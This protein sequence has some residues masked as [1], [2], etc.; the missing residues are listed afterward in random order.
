M[1]LFAWFR[2]SCQQSLSIRVQWIG[3]QVIDFSYFAE[4][5]SIHYA[6]SITYFSS[7]AQVMSDVKYGRFPF[8]LQSAKEL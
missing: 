3:I 1:R 7:Y 5:A 4:G 6:N 8:D 2:N